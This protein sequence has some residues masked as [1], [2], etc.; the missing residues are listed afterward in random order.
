MTV[1]IK[2]EH[3]RVNLYSQTQLQPSSMHIYLSHFPSARESL[4]SSSCLPSLGRSGG[5]GCWKMHREERTEEG[6]YVITDILVNV[7]LHKW[8]A[9]T[10]I[11]QWLL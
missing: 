4:T 1:S 8:K 7:T 10:W 3:E 6:C 5:G 11:F 2:L 9:L